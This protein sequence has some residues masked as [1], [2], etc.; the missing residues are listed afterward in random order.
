ML[1]ETRELNDS[2]SLIELINICNSGGI[3]Y[4]KEDS[5]LSLDLKTQHS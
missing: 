2:N 3:V 5:E 4:L 1:R